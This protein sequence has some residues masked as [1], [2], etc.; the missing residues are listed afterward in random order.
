MDLINVSGTILINND[1]TTVFD[2]FANPANDALWRKEINKSEVAGPLQEGVTVAEYA[3]LSKRTPNNLLELTCVQFIPNDSAVFET[4]GHSMFYLKSQR[5]VRSAADHATTVD[6]Q[7]E[8]DK[9]IVAFAVGVSLPRLIISWKA[10]RDLKKYLQQL[11]KCL[12][13]V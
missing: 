9:S 8:F 5:S 2:F 12:E 11:K 13:S 4:P 3:Y 6:Y 7:L 10:N 1:V